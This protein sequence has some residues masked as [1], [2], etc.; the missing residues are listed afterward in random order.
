MFFKSFNM[1]YLDVSMFEIL[2]LNEHPGDK[3]CLQMI[4]NFLRNFYSSV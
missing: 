3:Q 4:C 1:K 2:K